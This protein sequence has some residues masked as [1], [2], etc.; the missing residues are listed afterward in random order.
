MI[1]IS[2]VG[3]AAASAGPRKTTRAGAGFRV[4][5]AA[6]PGGAGETAPAAPVETLSALIALQSE[7]AGERGGRGKAVATA[8]LT[9][10]LLDRLRLGLIEG[11]ISMSDLEA[12]AHAAS[13]R[14]DAGGI[15]SGLAGLHEEIALRARV[16]LAK[17]GR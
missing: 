9:L 12:L 6:S 15:D 14:A 5:A 8:R 10:D 13:S 3:N 16:E 7:A 11:Q 1:R 17:L 2:G 4:D